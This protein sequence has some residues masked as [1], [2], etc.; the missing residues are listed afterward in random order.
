MKKPKFKI[1]DRVVRISMKSIYRLTNFE[2][3]EGNSFIVNDVVESLD[4]KTYYYQ[5]FRKKAV[6]EEELELESVYNSKLYN[7]LK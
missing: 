2:V 5:P 6:P 1:G 7:S 3:L 4:G